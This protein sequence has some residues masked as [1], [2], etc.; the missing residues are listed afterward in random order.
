MAGC[1]SLNA[2][3]PPNSPYGKY[4]MAVIQGSQTSTISITN[5]PVGGFP[6]VEFINTEK[7]FIGAGGINYMNSPWRGYYDHV[8]LYG[9]LTTYEYHWEG[10]TTLGQWTMVDH[11]LSE[12]EYLYYKSGMLTK[13]SSGGSGAYFNQGTSQ[14][15]IR[16]KT[17]VS[18]NNKYPLYAQVD[19]EYSI[20]RSKDMAYIST[21]KRSIKLAYPEQFNQLLLDQYSR[22][23]YR[24]TEVDL[25]YPPDKN[26]NGGMVTIVLDSTAVFMTMGTT[27]APQ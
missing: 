14:K 10:L 2:A 16:V 21:R 22:P 1:L 4:E 27:V 8:T 9:P 23:V 20:Y 6:T 13:P 15:L 3:P 5:Q 18:P 25:V 19:C 12:E 17:L 26:V 7:Q 11:Y 24:V